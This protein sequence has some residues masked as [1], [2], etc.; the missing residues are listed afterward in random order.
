MRSISFIIPRSS[1][2]LSSD[3]RMPFSTSWGM[4]S[5]MLSAWSPMRSISLTTWKY[6]AIMFASSSGSVFWL[7]LT[8]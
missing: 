5:T 4:S 1:A 2:T 3:M 8:R 6:A 7:I